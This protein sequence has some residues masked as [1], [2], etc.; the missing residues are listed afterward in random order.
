ML[1]YCEGAK[2]HKKNRIILIRITPLNESNWNAIFNM[3]GI[4]NLQTIDWLQI[5]QIGS[6]SFLLGVDLIYV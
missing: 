4:Q 5:V 6:D 2:K 1:Y 3:K